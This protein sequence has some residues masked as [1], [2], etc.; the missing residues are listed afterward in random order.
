MC[1]CVCVCTINLCVRLPYDVDID[2]NTDSRT[3]DG[4][5]T[6]HVDGTTDYS[7]LTPSLTHLLTD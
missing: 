7:E 2:A 1:V 5:K 6:D 4:I 3:V